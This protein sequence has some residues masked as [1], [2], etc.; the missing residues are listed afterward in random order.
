MNMGLELCLDKTI[1]QPT[2]EEI[3]NF[4]FH[5]DHS[6]KNGRHNLGPDAI[7]SRKA[8]IIDGFPD[9]EPLSPLGRRLIRCRQRAWMALWVIDRG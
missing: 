6:I 1:R 4:K 9:V 2:A 5:S 8:L 3:A 7:C